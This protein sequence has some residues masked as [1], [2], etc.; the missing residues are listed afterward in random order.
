MPTNRRLMDT[1]PEAATAETRRMLEWW[2][3]LRRA[4]DRHGIGT[5]R[6][7]GGDPDHGWFRPRP[8]EPGLDETDQGARPAHAMHPRH[9]DEGCTTAHPEDGHM[10]AEVD[11]H[12]RVFFGH[13]SDMKTPEAGRASASVSTHCIIISIWLRGLATA[14]IC[15][16][17]PRSTRCLRK[18][19]IPAGVRADGIRAER[20]VR[21][22]CSCP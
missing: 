15:S 1:P 11:A 6:A 3:A 7:L 13:W 18:C 12:R 5:A 22:F 19:D 16:S 9:Q 17:R 2:D 21:L 4:G 8:L 14:L 10:R 20:N